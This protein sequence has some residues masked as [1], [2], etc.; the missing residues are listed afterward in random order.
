LYIEP[1]ILETILNVLETEGISDVIVQL[2]GQTALNLAKELEGHGITLLGTDSD[3]IDKLEDRDLFYQML[4]SLE[5][6]HIQG[7]MADNEEQITALVAQ[8][9][10]PVL[11]RPSY[12]IG[13]KGMER[14]NNQEEL[15]SYLQ[16]DDIPY[17]VLVDQFMQASEA[18]LDLVADGE[19]ICV[20]ALMEHVEKTG[21]HSGDSLSILP[22]A[23]LTNNAKIKMKQF[24]EKIVKEVGYKGI[25]NIQYIVDG[26]DVYLLE[27]NPRASRT[28]PIVSK[29]TGVPLIQLATKILLG[30]YLSKEEI[31]ADTH[32]PYV[33]VKYPVFSNYA[34]KGLDSR[35]SPEMRSTGEGISI[36]ATYEE[37]LRKAFHVSLK[38]KTGHF[39][40]VSTLA[41]LDK[42]EEYAA[43]AGVKL[44][45]SDDAETS[46]ADPDT[47]AYY[48]PDGRT[49][50]KYLRSLATRNRVITFTEKESLIAFLNALTIKGF[51]VHSIEEWHN[52]LK[53]DVDAV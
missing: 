13:G 51:T 18:E 38:Q 30:K 47:I 6:A 41:E 8:I 35:L 14:I 50:D 46:L 16:N 23:N 34:L 21:V 42:A 15:A 26:D 9:G 25:M 32:I 49:E 28:V 36:A 20:P 31:E 29:V 33:C 45:L 7:D 53:R 40:L 43:Q 10:F 11:I 48:N 22:A 44:I 4:D 37:A 27:V 39:I 17:P 12:V 24:A 52:L 2:G 1:L 5:I 19:N 3:T